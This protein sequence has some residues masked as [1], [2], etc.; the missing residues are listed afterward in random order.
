MSSSSRPSPP[1]WIPSDRLQHRHSY[2]ALSDKSPVSDE[3]L[4][5]IVFNAVKH[6]PTS[7]NNQTTGA[8]LVLGEKHQELWKLVKKSLQ[9]K[10]GEENGRSRVCTGLAVR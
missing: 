1:Q 5:E 8:A 4:R 2:Y 3:K 6:V 9:D 10:H 7:F